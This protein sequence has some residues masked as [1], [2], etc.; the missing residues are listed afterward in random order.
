MAVYDYE[1]KKCGKVIE[2]EHGLSEDPP[3]KKCEDCKGKLV[4]LFSPPSIVFKG[5]G[6]Y[7]NDNKSSGRKPAPCGDKAPKP[8][9][10][11][12]T[13]SSACGGCAGATGSGD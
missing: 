2:Q 11:C 4:K 6:F 12:S 1:C 13:S 9:E 3:L 5:S 10:S 7:I 8:G